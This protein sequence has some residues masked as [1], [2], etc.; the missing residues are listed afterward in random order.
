M[1][2]FNEQQCL[3]DTSITEDRG[4]E[5]VEKTRMQWRGSGDS[6]REEEAELWILTPTTMTIKLFEKC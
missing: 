3:G 5:K 1:I 2:T 4:G 6:G